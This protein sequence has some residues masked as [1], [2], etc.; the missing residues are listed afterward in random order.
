MEIEIYPRE[1]DLTSVQQEDREKATLD[2]AAPTEFYL[3]INNWRPLKMI[4]WLT[5]IRGPPFGYLG[6]GPLGP[7]GSLARHAV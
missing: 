7:P 3:Q 4:K 1:T 6:R 5:E 2:Q